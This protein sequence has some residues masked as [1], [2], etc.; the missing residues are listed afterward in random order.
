[1]NET[2]VVIQK[3]SINKHFERIRIEEA[4]EMRS[5]KIQTDNSGDKD[6]KLMHK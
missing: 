3:S 1:M 5:I 2:I 4:K 6:V